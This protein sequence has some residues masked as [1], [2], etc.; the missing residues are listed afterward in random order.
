MDV[1][2]EKSQQKSVTTKGDLTNKRNANLRTQIIC[3]A[4]HSNLYTHTCG[5]AR[6]AKLNM[7]TQKEK[8]FVR[9]TQ[10]LI[11]FFER[12]KVT[13]GQAPSVPGG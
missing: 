9:R 5:R 11:F 2:S 1:P 8:S 6:T 13:P 12:C 4:V 10:P 3:V 7:C